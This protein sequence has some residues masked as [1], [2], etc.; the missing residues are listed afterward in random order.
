MYMN[1]KK[2]GWLLFVYTYVCLVLECSSYA[3]ILCWLM[4]ILFDYIL[5]LDI[6]F[7]K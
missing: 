7:I 5:F 4:K 3:A 2:V 1:I 6:S